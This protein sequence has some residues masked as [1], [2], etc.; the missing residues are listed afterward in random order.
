L[1]KAKDY[2]K[3]KMSLLLES[4]DQQAIFYTMQ[5]ILE[6]KILAPEEIFSKIDKVSR[7][8]ILKLAKDIFR[9]EKL[10][11]AII[12]PF[13]DKNKFQKLLKI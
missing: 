11:L 12:G 3:G 9:P 2:F 8:D 7:E 6:K 1:Q 4:S 5:D 13:K 10:N